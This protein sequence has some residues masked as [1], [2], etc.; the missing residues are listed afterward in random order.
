MEKRLWGLSKKLRREL[1]YG[2]VIP[3]LHICLKNMKTLIQNIHILCTPMLTAVLFTTAK[4]RKQPKCP[5]M[6]E[7]IKRM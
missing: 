1:L 3:L 4:I 6:N 5:L 2:P 7:W